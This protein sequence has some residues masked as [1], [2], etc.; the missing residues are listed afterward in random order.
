MDRPEHKNAKRFLG[1]EVEA[2]PMQGHRTLFVIGLQDVDETISLAQEHNIEH[3]YLGANMSF[4]PYG[5]LEWESWKHTV[6]QLLDAD[7]WVTL[8]YDRVYHEKVQEMGHQSSAKFISM[9]SVKLPNIKNLNA[10]ACLK[11][12]D[13]DFK[14][15]NTG[16]WVHRVCDLQNYECYTDWSAYTKDEVIK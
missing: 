12:D 13:K 1:T 5:T 16:V 6:D 7:L 4:H 9:I 8:D 15:S 3:V 10:N 11:I 2:T 14:F